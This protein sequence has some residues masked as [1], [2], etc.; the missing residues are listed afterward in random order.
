MMMEFSLFIM[1]QMFVMGGLKTIEFPT[2]AHLGVFA[3]MLMM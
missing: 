3:L 2:N 1:F